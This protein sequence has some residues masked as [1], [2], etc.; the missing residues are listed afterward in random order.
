MARPRVRE[1]LLDA[2]YCVLQNEGVSA[3]TTRYIAKQAGTTEA[4]VFNNFGDKAGL[5]YALIG[6]RLPEVRSVQQAIAAQLDGNPRPW[7]EEI[8]RTAEQFYFL[9]LP[10]TFPLWR[11][12][13]G[14]EGSTHF[15]LHRALHSALQALQVRGSI[16]KTADTGVLA[17]LLLGAALHAAMN[18]LAQG[19]SALAEEGAAG[20]AERII[21]S[22]ASLLIHA[23]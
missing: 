14:P 5:M 15:P 13:S 7:L 2:A 1:R 22:L 16:S 11:G 6:E 18:R 9:V 3:L 4:S 12:G 19:E 10:L 8:Y 21:A 23:E 20:G 17:T